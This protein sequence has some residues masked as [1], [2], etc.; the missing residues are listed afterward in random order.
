MNVQFECNISALRCFWKLTKVFPAMFEP[1]KPLILLV[2]INFPVPT[3]FRES[4]DVRT[5]SK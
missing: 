1:Q 5:E 4:L 3:A 2:F